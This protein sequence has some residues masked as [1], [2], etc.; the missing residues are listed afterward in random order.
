MAA[1]WDTYGLV[2]M[3]RAGQGFVYGK[4]KAQTAREKK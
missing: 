2:G 1:S 3:V 4:L